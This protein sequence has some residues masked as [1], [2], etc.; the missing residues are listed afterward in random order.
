MSEAIFSY[1]KAVYLFLSIRKT[2]K[3]YRKVG[4]FNSLNRP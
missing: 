4:L 1:F 3:R 2:E